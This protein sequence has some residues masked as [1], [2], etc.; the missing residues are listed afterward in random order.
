MLKISR[1]LILKR[2]IALFFIFLHVA[3]VIGCGYGFQGGGSVLP[4]DVK[5]VYV[6][7]AD[8]LSPEVGLTLIVTE[9]MRDRFDRFGVVSVV[10]S[11]AAA[12]AILKIAIVSVKRDTSANA[13]GTNTQLKQNAIITVAGELKKTTGEVLW[14]TSGLTVKRAFA[15]TAN[16]V[17]ASSP[18]F[19]A[20]GFGS[21]DLANLGDREITRGAE[22]ATFELLAT[23]VATLVYDQAVSPD[24]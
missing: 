19:A 15:N 22:K 7:M 1:S 6:P 10:D 12:D 16:S 4:P 20:T 23:D 13:S 3:S 18:D 14:R 21:A 2:V 5:R 17:V 11:Q 9:A 8:N 24:F